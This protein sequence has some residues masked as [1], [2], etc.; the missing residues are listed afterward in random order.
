[1]AE[2]S[3]SISDQMSLGELLRSVGIMGQATRT[4]LKQEKN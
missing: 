2:N 3:P 4:L 1:M